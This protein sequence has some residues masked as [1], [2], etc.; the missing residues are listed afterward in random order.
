ML[1]GN[2]GTW[3]VNPVAVRMFTLSHGRPL[4]PLNAAFLA[5]STKLERMTKREIHR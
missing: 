1:S 3:T 2:V 4:L 5:M